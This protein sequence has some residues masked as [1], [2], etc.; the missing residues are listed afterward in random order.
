MLKLVISNT[1]LDTKSS[2]PSQAPSLPSGG[3]PFTAKIILR[4]PSLYSLAACD[5]SHHL[6]CELLLETL[7]NEQENEYENSLEP[8]IVICHYPIIPDDDLNHYVWEDE[9]LLGITLIQFQMKLMEQLLLFCTNHNASQLKIYAD[10][11]QEETLGIYREY[12]YANGSNLDRSGDNAQIIMPMCQQVSQDWLSFM[13]KVT[14]DFRQT[15]WR[16]QRTNPAIRHYLKHHP[17]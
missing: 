2:Q 13:N 4:G 16:D 7:A 1:D 15:L 6:N 3:A 12:L 8:K 11:G 5:P 9:T 10:D 14:L 17:L